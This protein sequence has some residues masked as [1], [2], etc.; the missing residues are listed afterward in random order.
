MEN[1]LNQVPLANLNLNELNQVKELE[2]KMGEK[3]YLIA[4]KRDEKLS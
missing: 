3:F 1:K 2:N 4:F